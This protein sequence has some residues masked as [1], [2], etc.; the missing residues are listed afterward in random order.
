MFKASF[1]VLKFII[2]YSENCH[3]SF[4]IVCGHDF[5]SVESCASVSCSDGTEAVGEPALQRRRCL[6]RSA[7]ARKPVGGL[8]ITRAFGMK[9]CTELGAK[10][11]P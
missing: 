7:T 1:Q 10:R 6:P 8:K 5:S 2:L 4:K 11:P 9:L 3:N